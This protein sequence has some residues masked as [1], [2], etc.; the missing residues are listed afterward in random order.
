MTS[1]EKRSAPQVFLHV[2]EPKSGTTFLQDVMWDNRDELARQGVLLPGLAAQ[3]HFRADQDLREVPQAPDD[4]SGSYRGEWDLLAKQALQADHAA[5]ISHELLA[6]ATARQAKRALASLDGAEVHIILTV[7]DFVR[8]LPAEWQET[9][10]HRNTGSWQQWLRRVM[11][12]ERVQGPARPWFWRVHDTLSVLERWSQGLPPDQVH[13]VTVPPPGS[14]P[15]LLWRRF[16]SVLGLDPDRADIRAAR[17]N[18]SLPLPEAELL[19]RLNV[20]LAEDR[21]PDWFYAVHVKERIAHDVLAARA[22]TLRPRLEGRAD[23]W[24]RARAAKVVAGLRESGYDIVG[25]LDDLEPPEPG[26]GPAGRAAGRVPTDAVLDAAV[27]TLAAVVRR[28]YET[29]ERGSGQPLPARL[30]PSVKRTVRDLTARHP[31]L[32]RVRVLAWRVS[33]RTWRR[34]QTR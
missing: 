13:V 29:Q 21:L 1:R 11:R 31:S 32:G 7:R 3:D 8:L 10:K 28:D 4:P 25:S 6:A 16:A 17:A 9:I 19:R 15:E 22:A 33:E 20:E 34:R 27:A 5:V 2:G 12:T 30:A 24:A 18:T 26:S 23:E 14:P